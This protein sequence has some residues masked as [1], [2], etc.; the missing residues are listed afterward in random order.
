MPDR[1]ATVQPPANRYDAVVARAAVTIPR[2]QPPNTPA[3]PSLDGSRTW[4][5]AW[6]DKP[7]LNHPLM[8][9]VPGEARATNAAGTIP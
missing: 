3:E 4:H 9:A 5:K 6:V 1:M 2:W 8:A 7:Q